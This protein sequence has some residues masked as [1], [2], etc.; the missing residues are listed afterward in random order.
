MHLA[1]DSGAESDSIPLPESDICWLL[2]HMHKYEKDHCIIHEPS[3]FS[4]PGNL[5]P[6]LDPRTRSVARGRPATME[7]CCSAHTT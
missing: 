3:V 2:A 1:W 5:G 6:E 7:Q 4:I